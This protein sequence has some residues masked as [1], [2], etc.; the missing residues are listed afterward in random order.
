MNVKTG[1]YVWKMR[2]QEC[3]MQISIYNDHSKKY[4]KHILAK[5]S[6]SRYRNTV[7]KNWDCHLAGGKHESSDFI[8]ICTKYLLGECL[9]YRNTC[10]IFHRVWRV[11]L[12]SWI[13]DKLFLFLPRLFTLCLSLR[14]EAEMSR[15]LLIQ[16]REQALTSILGA[17][18]QKTTMR[19]ILLL[20]ERQNHFNS[21]PKPVPILNRLSH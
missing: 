15:L 11:S 3:V 13:S 4:Q 20:W 17:W 14:P 5:Y 9:L 8:E 10:R 1:V 21:R 12:F 2:M 16:F 6:Q 18:T 19:F 7:D